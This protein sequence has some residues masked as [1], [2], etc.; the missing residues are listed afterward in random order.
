M[1]AKV[2]EGILEELFD[3]NSIIDEYMNMLDYNTIFNCLGEFKKQ[4]GVDVESLAV[5]VFQYAFYLLMLKF[6]WKCFNIYILNVDGDDDASP[7]VLLINFVKAIVCSLGFGLLFSYLCGIGSEITGHILERI[8]VETMSYT[9]VVNKLNVLDIAYSLFLRL[10]FGVFTLLA[11]ILSVKFIKSAVQ[12]VILRVGIAFA[13]IGLLDS[14][15]GMFKPYIKK[16]FQIVA[17]VVVQV[18][19]LRLSLYAAST[20]SFIWAFALLSMAM[21]APAFLQEFIMTNP[22]TGKLQQALYSFSIMRS[23]TRR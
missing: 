2:L 11:I 12:L 9:D 3:T 10:C 14:D 18:G 5:I 20:A 22:G 13:S 17:A 6:V 16:F 19:C 4:L 23:F 1:G 7:T 8:Q 15:Q 21:T